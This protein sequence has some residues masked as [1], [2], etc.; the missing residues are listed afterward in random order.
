M[1]SDIIRQAYTESTRRAIW[2]HSYIYNEYLAEAG[3]NSWENNC[4]KHA[5]MCHNLEQFATP[6]Q[7]TAEIYTKS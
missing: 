1:Q 7:P 4:D 3:L 6:S 5:N 2:K